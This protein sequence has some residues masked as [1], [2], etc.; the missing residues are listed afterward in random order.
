MT[1]LVSASPTVTSFVTVPRVSCQTL[2]VYLPGRELAE[3]ELAAGAGDGVEGVLGDH[4]PRAHP[5]MEVAVDPDDLGLGEGD[6]NGPPLR[7][8]P[9]E[10]GIALA[11]AV[12]VVEQAIAVQELHGAADR[13]HDDARHEHA[14]LLIEGDRRRG[15][16]AASRRRR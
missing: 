3:R 10:D 2:R 5:R 13:D 11:V 14:L 15:D 12:D 4:D 7:L 8:R 6:R 9:V 16:L 1:T